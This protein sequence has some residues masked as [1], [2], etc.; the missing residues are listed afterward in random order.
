MPTGPIAPKETKRGSLFDA[1]DHDDDRSADKG[2][3]GKDRSAPADVV[4]DMDGAEHDLPA[5]Y[6]ALVSL[7]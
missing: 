3:D 5:R 4:V 1:Q 7:S 6:A 2:A